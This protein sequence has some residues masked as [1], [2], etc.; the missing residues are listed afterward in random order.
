M[1]HQAALDRL[2]FEDIVD[3][4]RREFPEQYIWSR[5][6]K[7]G[8]LVGQV[9]IELDAGEWS[10]N[11]NLLTR[12]ASAGFEQDEQFRYLANTQGGLGITVNSLDAMEFLSWSEGPPTMIGGFDIDCRLLSDAEI[13]QAQQLVREKATSSAA[14]LRAEAQ[15]REDRRDAQVSEARERKRHAGYSV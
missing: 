15:A 12:L 14:M 5:D 1:Y 10:V 3:G 6:T 7:V 8:D 11:E 9:W 13:E 4:W 2:R